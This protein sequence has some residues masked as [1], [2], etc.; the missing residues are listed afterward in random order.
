MW[1]AWVNQVITFCTIGLYFVFLQLISKEFLQEYF[2]PF[3][4]PVASAHSMVII[5]YIFGVG[6]LFYLSLFT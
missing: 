1:F 5:L 6:S 4:G 3:L 2:L